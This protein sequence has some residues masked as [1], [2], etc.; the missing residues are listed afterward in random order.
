METDRTIAR[1]DTSAWRDRLEQ[2][3]RLDPAA[4]QP[5]VDPAWHEPMVREAEQTGNA[6]AAIWHLDR[7][8]AAHPDDWFLYAR[9]AR[10]WSLSDQFDK[11]AA[12]YAAGR[13]ARLA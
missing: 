13:A 6:F 2:L 11:A 4:L 5:D 10:A 8:I 9:R 7:L 3:G 1:L 12:D